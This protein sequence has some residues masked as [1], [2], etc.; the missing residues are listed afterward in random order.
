MIIDKDKMRYALNCEK[1]VAG[2][3]KCFNRKKPPDNTVI[4]LGDPALVL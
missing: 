1:P 4:E 3:Y 2:S